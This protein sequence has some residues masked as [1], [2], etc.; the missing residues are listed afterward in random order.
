MME[1]EDRVIIPDGE[2]WWDSREEKEENVFKEKSIVE[3]SWG[4][5]VDE[6]T[7]TLGFKGFFYFK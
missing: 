6:L 3:R 7:S 5:V 4:E 1:R 2:V